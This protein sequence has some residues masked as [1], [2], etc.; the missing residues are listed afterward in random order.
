MPKEKR[1]TVTLPGD[2]HQKLK[3]RCALDDVRMGDVVRNL[4]EQECAAPLGTKPEK[5][6]AR[7]KSKTGAEAA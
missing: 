7:A 2:L 6:R 3:I 4:V 1:F 5:G